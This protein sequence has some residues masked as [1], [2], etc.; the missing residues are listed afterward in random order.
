[1][2]I[3]LLLER[4]PFPQVLTETLR[5]YW[6][7]RYGQAYEV[8]WQWG[9]PGR[10]TQ[11][12]TWWVNIYLN[13]I[14]TPNLENAAFDPIRRE[15][16]Y[17]LVR[18]RR[19]LQRAYVRV[20]TSRYLAGHLAQ[21]AL[22]VSP[23][24]EP[25]RDLLIV[26][27]NHKIRIL[28]HRKKRS[29][30]LLKSGFPDRFWERELQSR[31]TAARCGLPVPE[32]ERAAPSR[33]WYSEAYISGTPL[34]RLRDS[35]QAHRA[36]ETV[37]AKLP[38]LYEQTATATPLNQY[39]AALEA[40]INELAVRNPLLNS[41]QTR[42]IRELARSLGAN[43]QGIRSPVQLCLAHGDFQ[44]ANIL[45]DGGKTWLIDWEYAAQRQRGY[46][47]LVYG[48]EAR[49]PRDLDKR[50]ISFVENGLPPDLPL[51]VPWKTAAERQLAA[52]I[53]Y[54]EEL[55]HHLEENDNPLFTRIGDGLLTLLLTGEKFHNR[56]LSGLPIRTT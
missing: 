33:P 29:V 17:S 51:P 35:A 14:F 11:S 46:D 54:L 7:A 41:A 42:Q 21:A 31:Q 27:G 28:N 56:Q 40:Q 16:G 32:M 6:S 13:A 50:L 22:R 53:F 37:T 1:M 34:N 39:A 44:P 24:V 8:A 49:F 19:P 15:F 45:F 25:A 10:Q 48:L 12:Q 47:A 38:A 9:R 55:L 26:P 52:Q 43:L 20:A 18:W 5:R 3:S 4:E 30:V 36:L 2:R 23:P